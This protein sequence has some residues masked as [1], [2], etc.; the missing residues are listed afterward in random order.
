MDWLQT[1]RVTYCD[2]ILIPLFAL[3]VREPM[4]EVQVKRRGF[5]LLSGYPGHFGST[6]G[7]LPVSIPSLLRRPYRRWPLWVTAVT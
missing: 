1:T 4:P 3:T 2:G 5:G 7:S 6:A